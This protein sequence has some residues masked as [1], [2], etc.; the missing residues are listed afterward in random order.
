MEGI[1]KKSTILAFLLFPLL[2][3]IFL[4][5]SSARADIFNYNSKYQFNKDLNSYSYLGECGLDRS[6]NLNLVFAG[7]THNERGVN[8]AKADREL[9]KRI[10]DGDFNMINLESAI[11]KH[12]ERVLKEYNFKT[13]FNFLR[14][15]ESLNINGV[16]IANNHSFDYGWVGF[17]DTLKNLERSNL[18]YSG[19]GESLKRALLPITISKCSSKVAI[20]GVNDVIPTLDTLVSSKRGGVLGINYLNSVRSVVKRYKEDGYYFIV[21]THSGVERAKEPSDREK[22]LFKELSMMGADAII[23]SHPHVRERVEYDGGVLR[24]YSLGNFIFYSRGLEERMGRVLK[25]EICES[26]LVS[27]KVLDGEIKFGIGSFTKLFNEFRR[28]IS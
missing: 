19:G 1:V 7:D 14:I 17:K 24:A 25:L 28:S 3:N 10:F 18:L 26:R 22:R 2:G 8:L 9:F 12:S 20:L 15:L 5:G 4:I 21:F 16:S 11:T 23:N 27:Y 6:S 13:D